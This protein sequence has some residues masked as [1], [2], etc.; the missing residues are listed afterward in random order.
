MPNYDFK[1]LSPHD[2][3]LLS[4]DLIQERDELILESFTT[5]RDSGI[6]FRYAQAEGNCIVQCKHYA[7][8]GFSGLLSSLKKEAKKVLKLNPT[9]YILSTSVGLTPKN[10]QDIKNLFGNVLKTEDILGQADLN[11]LLGL[12]DQVEK[13]HYKL[14]LTSSAVLDQVMHNES[15]IQSGFE[16]ERVL[17]DIRRYVRSDAYPNACNLLEKNYVVII[18]GIPGVGKTTLARILLYTYLERG[19]EPVS[20]LMDFSEARKR[21]KPGKKQIFYFDDFIGATFLGERVSSFTRN[22]DRSIL[23]FIELVQS[24]GTAR[25]IMTTREHILQQAFISSEKIK[26]S[27][28]LENKYVLKIGDYRPMQRAEI[29]YNHIYFSGLPK[30]YRDILLTDRF[31]TKIIEHKKFNPRL[32]QWLSDIQ[33]LSSVSSDDYQSFILSLLANPAEIWLHAYEHQI[34][35]AA[36]S[37]LLTLYTYKGECNI[38]RLEQAFRVLHELRAKRYSFKTAPS[39]WRHALR[40]LNGSFVF[41]GQK[42]EVIDPSVLDMLNAIVRDDTLNALDMLEGTIEFEQASRICI[43]AIS[44][45]SSTVLDLFIRE[46]DRVAN[47][48]KSFLQF[49]PPKQETVSGITVTYAES[50]ELRL[51]TVIRIAEKLSSEELLEVI[52]STFEKLLARWASEDGGVNIEDGL[53]LLKSIDSS[54]FNFESS[55]E[56]IRIQLIHKMVEKASE[57]SCNFMQFYELLNIVKSEGLYSELSFE[58]SVIAQEYRIYSFKDDLDSCQS[59]SEYDDLEGVLTE[60][61]EQISIINF[62][63]VINSIHDEKLKLEENKLEYANDAY[64]EW[65]EYQNTAESENQEIDNL[66]DLL[67]E[68]DG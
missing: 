39:D 45:D 22:E 16:I 42:V 50:L 15:F 56:D 3:E 61:S 10:K 4:R 38:H 29:L 1:Q 55:N 7:E 8:T 32:I 37:I 27:D 43:F 49:D 65:K 13:R 21:Y 46:S 23:D 59:E 54:N 53:S 28:I 64:E 2:F 33:R 47:I 66:F 31:Y 14:W 36:R 18:S 9:R 5:G 6:D 48:L 35:D 24:S 11:N 40:E 60:I 51:S 68:P 26:Q 12:Y 52:T 34:S 25:L 41:S 67:R 30:N 58:F 17:R 20:I 57:E 63:E 19:F 62:D 44:N